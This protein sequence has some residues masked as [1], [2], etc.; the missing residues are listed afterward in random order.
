MGVLGYLDNT[1]T[2]IKKIVEVIPLAMVDDLMAVSSCGMDSIEMN[3]SINALIELKTYRSI[4]QLRIKRVSA[5]SC[6]LGEK[7]QSDMKVHGHTVDSV[8]QAVYLGDVLDVTGS[9]GGNIKGVQRYGA[10]QYNSKPAK[11]S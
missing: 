10:S 3:T 4:S 11:N 5:M 2:I 1:N 7:I 8:S 9:N 6:T